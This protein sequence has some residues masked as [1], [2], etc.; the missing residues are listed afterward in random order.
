MFDWTASPESW[1]ALATLTVLEI[2]LGVD[3]I[4][5]ISILADRLPREQRE[6]A[7]K[8]GL[9]LAMV[10]RLALLFSL[11]WIIGLEAP[12]VEVAG[13]EISGRDLILLAGGLFLLVQATRE[14]HGQVEGEGPE[15]VEPGFGTTLGGVLVQIALLD[16]VFSLDSVITAVGMAREVAVMAIAIVVAVGVMVVLIGPISSFIRDHPTVKILA[17]SFLV[18]IGVA[19]V[20]DAFDRHLPRGYIYFAFA[21]STFVEVLQLRADDGK[22]A[23]E[24]G[25]GGRTGGGA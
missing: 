21:F 25:G 8:V 10:T 2:V 11:A 16:T 20:A 13:Q 4:V 5:M 17:L 18:L 3:N 7:R 14:I 22:A 24:T 9:A 15:A 19:L 6:L 23:A 12:F 1:I